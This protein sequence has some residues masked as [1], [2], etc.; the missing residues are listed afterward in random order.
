MPEFMKVFGQ[1]ASAKEMT[2]RELTPAVAEILKSVP[3]AIRLGVE[4][5]RKK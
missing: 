2:M 5:A 3:D 4:E 1:I